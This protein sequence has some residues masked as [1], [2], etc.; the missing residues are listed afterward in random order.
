MTSKMYSTYAEQYDLAVQENIYNALLERPS[1]KALLGK[2]NGLEVIDLGCGSGIYAQYLVEQLASR[3]TCI[4]VSAQMVELVKSKLGT[5]VSAYCQDLSLGLPQEGDS[6][7]D[8]VICPL[9][10]H[11]L[12]DL[13]LF[14]AEIFRVLKP[15]GYLVLSTHHPMVDFE[16]SPSGN[17][18]KREL[19]N[20]VWHTIGMPVEVSFFRRSLT[21]LMTAI[22]DS[23]LVITGVK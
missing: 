1:L 4:D 11:Y 3:V 18:F 10:I 7:A 21:E 8:V 6:S 23:G 9:M 15:N 2:L 12:E 17:Y 19:I 14:F 16:V 5:K 13:T 20:D 22:T